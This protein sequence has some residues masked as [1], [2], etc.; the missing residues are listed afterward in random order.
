MRSAPV[1]HPYPETLMAPRFA[2]LA[3]VPL[4]LLLAGCAATPAPAS[5]PSSDASLTIQNC[6]T[7]VTFDAAP[8]RVV[9]IKSTSVEMMLALGV[10]DR[11]VGTAF[12]DGPVPDEWADEAAG[13]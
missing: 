8:E 2:P 3:S 7:S 9:A 12:T 6:D 1:H 11:I 5:A 13:L 4:L 10:G